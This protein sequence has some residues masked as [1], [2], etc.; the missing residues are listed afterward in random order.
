MKLEPKVKESLMNN[1]ETFL[2]HVQYNSVLERI[3]EKNKSR[4]TLIK[5]DERIKLIEKQISE[6]EE[7]KQ[8]ISNELTSELDV[9]LIELTDS[10]EHYC[11]YVL[12]KTTDDHDGYSRC[13]YN[14][15]EYYQCSICGKK[16]QRDGIRNA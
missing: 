7:K 8:S 15:T 5:N 6:L 10:L 14:Y 13:K 16:M 4:N 11:D 9:E 12:Y 1:E 2:K 3:K